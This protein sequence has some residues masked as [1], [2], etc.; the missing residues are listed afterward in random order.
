MIEADIAA[1][2]AV[3]ARPK[4]ALRARLA[5]VSFRVSVVILF[6]LVLAP[7]FHDPGAEMDEGSVLAYSDRVV[8]GA[9]PWRSFESFYGPAN[10]WL[11]ALARSFGGGIGAERAVGF[12]YR[13]AIVL[14]LLALAR[15]Y[16]VA[17]VCL[18]VLACALILP[19]QGVAAY[20]LVGGIGF[21][22]CGLALCSTALTTEPDRP[23]ASRRSFAAGA[24]CG[25][26]TLERFDLILA[27]GLAAAVLLPALGRRRRRFAVAG[28]ATVSTPMPYRS[29]ARDSRASNDSSASSAPLSPGAGFPIRRLRSFRETSSRR[30]FSARSSSCS[31]AECFSRGG[32]A[33]VTP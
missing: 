10:V 12:L 30:R 26:A 13:V 21:G 16:G 32:A 14:A 27:L 28:Y 7:R 24:L 11:V 20:S 22:L 8:H 5:E 23:S 3:A 31:S 9:V 4:G 18:T 6:A 17:A 15:R 19:G 29:N 25:L 1:G 33:T 2:A